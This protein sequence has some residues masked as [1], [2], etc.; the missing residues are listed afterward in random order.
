MLA[1]A[2]AWLDDHPVTAFWGDTMRFESALRD[3]T[4][5]RETV[6]RW[7]DH[8]RWPIKAEFRLLGWVAACFEQ[9]PTA[10]GD[11]G[12]MFEQRLLAPRDAG[13]LVA[14]AHPQYRPTLTRCL[15]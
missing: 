4:V 9:E 15:P 5:Q 1:R 14:A 10:A 12:R 11:L 6:L 3:G 13:N 7:R 2:T 8:R